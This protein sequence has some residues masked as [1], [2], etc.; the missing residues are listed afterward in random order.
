MEGGRTA[1]GT[2]DGA[3]NLLRERDLGAGRAG[4]RVTGLLS[5]LAYYRSVGFDREL[6][7]L[8]T[9]IARLN[10]EY[11]GFLYGSATRPPVESRKHVDQMLRRLSEAN[12]DSAAER[13]RFSVLQ[14]RYNSLLERWER[15]QDEKESG[16]RPGLYG[17]F[18]PGREAA[19]RSTPSNARDPGSVSRNEAPGASDRVLFE[20]FLDA[21]KARGETVDGYRLQ[22]FLEGLTRQRDQLRSRLGTDDIEFDVVER[23]GEV[24]LVARRRGRT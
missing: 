20:R 9:A 6:R 15:L 13:F 24:K 4:E 21:K 7:V 5:R 22:E 3:R 2:A 23:S 16:R 18:V 11:D 12:I 14:G 8:E 19:P 10:A 1:S 17:H